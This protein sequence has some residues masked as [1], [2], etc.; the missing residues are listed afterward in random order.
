MRNVHVFYSGHF[1]H[2]M[3]LLPCLLYGNELAGDLSS[4]SSNS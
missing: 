4:S 2:W 1:S 3:L